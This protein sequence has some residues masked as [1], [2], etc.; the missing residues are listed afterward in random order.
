MDIDYAT[1][2]SM[3]KSET[4]TLMIPGFKGRSSSIGVTENKEV[5]KEL[6]GMNPDIAKEIAKNG[7]YWG[8]QPFTSSPYSGAIIVFLFIL[9]L[10]TVEGRMKWANIQRV[11]KYQD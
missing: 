7:Q 8:D 3:G 6:Q 5:M 11:N 2:W 9:A 4:M 10:F 1:Q